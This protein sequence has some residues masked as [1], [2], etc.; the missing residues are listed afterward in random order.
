MPL[1]Y[2]NINLTV[3][4]VDACVLEGI[5]NTF[6][7]IVDIATASVRWKCVQGYRKTAVEWRCFPAAQEGKDVL[8]ERPA[9]PADQCS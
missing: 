1:S 9:L 7:K 2:Q 4:V 8:A 3:V 5:K 6:L